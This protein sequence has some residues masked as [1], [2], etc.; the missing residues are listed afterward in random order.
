MK[1]KYILGHT[2]V[3][4]YCAFIHGDPHHYQNNP[5]I[6]EIVRRIEAAKPSNRTLRDLVAP[7][8]LLKD[9]THTAMNLTILRDEQLFYALNGSKLVA[10]YRATRPKQDEKP[11]RKP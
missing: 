7:G 10:V 6:T 9:K 3:E 5:I 11:S 4:N 2:A 8:I 1:H